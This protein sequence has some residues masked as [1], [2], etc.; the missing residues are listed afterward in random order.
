MTADRKA[1]AVAWAYGVLG[2]VPFAVSGVL[3]ATARGDVKAGARRGLVLYAG[4]ILSFLGGGRW[5]LE[6]GRKP[7]RASV[8]SG[9]MAP[10]VGGFLCLLFLSSRPRLQLAALEAGYGAQWLWDARSRDVPAWYP[11]LRSVLTA[12]AACALSAALIS[13]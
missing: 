13:A 11:G 2:L 4:L 5:G 8:I 10:T 7:V 6:I 1:P 3:A 12:G 9:S